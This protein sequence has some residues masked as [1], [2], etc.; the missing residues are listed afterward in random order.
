MLLS[1]MRIG[2]LSLLCIAAETVSVH[3]AD[4]SLAWPSKPVR[5]VNPYTAGGGV[6]VVGRAIAQQLN[7]AWGQPVI[8][9][10]RPGAGTTI[11]RMC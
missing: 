7:E 5:I 10:N 8:I 2:C 4:L 3:A 6:D 11:G 1:K 9:D